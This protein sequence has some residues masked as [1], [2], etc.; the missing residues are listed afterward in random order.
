MAHTADGDRSIGANLRKFREAL[1][2]SRET[3]SRESGISVATIARVEL[4][5]QLPT[6]GTL[7]ALAEALNVP[8]AALWESPDKAGAA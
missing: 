5:G 7:S 6:V 2:W 3:L 1:G 8:P 4:Y